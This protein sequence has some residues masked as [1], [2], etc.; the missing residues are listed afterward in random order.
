M[1]DKIKNILGIEGLKIEIS[2]PEAI[3]KEAKQINGSLQ[4]SSKRNQKVDTIVIQ[5]IEKYKRGREEDTLINE[6]V[7]S[8]IKLD[9][10]LEINSEQAKTIE[11]ELPLNLLK[12]E[13]DQLESKNFLTKGLVTFAKKIKNVQSYYRIEVSA[14]VKETSIQALATKKILLN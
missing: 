14:K 4:L 8:E 3:S 9:V 1:F 10:D 12:S 11:F 6:Y 2:V 5:L 13:M 7:L